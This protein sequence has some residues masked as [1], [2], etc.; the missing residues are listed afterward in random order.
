MVC[1]SKSQYRTRRENTVYRYAPL[2]VFLG[3]L[4]AVVVLV[5]L[6]LALLLLLLLLCSFRSCFTGWFSFSSAVAS[7]S[8]CHAFFHLLFVQH[9]VPKS[10]W[11]AIQH[12][13]PIHIIPRT[14]TIFANMSEQIGI[15]QT[16]SSISINITISTSTSGGTSAVTV[17][18]TQSNQPFLLQL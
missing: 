13:F 18:Q 2:F 1:K 17:P 6:A 3:L 9:V 10:P 7:F 16:N 8:A 5:V 14:G 15:H 11:P 4:L 12:P